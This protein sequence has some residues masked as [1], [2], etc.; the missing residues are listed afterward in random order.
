MQ[1][2]V[3]SLHGFLGSDRRNLLEI[4]TADQDAVNALGLSHEQ[5]ANRLQELTTAAQK[6]LGTAVVLERRYEVRYD[7]SRGTISSPFGSTRRFPKDTL[8]LKDIES[9]ETLQWSSLSI[10]MIREHGFYGGIGSPYRVDPARAARIL[11]L[12]R[13]TSP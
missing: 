10:H 7:E 8:Y 13:I 6:A 11:H 5:I 4:L 9:G 2:G 12:S 1:P 3:I